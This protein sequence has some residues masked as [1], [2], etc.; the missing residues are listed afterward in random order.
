V[1]GWKKG[2]AEDEVA[3]ARISSLLVGEG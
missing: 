1:E 3:L 2:V